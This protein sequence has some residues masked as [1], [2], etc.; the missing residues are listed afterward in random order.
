MMMKSYL[1]R[2]S[3]MNDLNVSEEKMSAAFTVVFSPA[4]TSAS[5]PAG[6]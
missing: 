2:I 1:L 6:R 4:K 5:N 3:L